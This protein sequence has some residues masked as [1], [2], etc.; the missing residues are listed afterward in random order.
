MESLDLKKIVVTKVFWK[1][2]LNMLTNFAFMTQNGKFAAFINCQKKWND[3]FNKT[4]KDRESMCVCKIWCFYENGVFFTIFLMLISIFPFVNTSKALKYTDQSCCI[5]CASAWQQC[6]IF[7]FA[8][9]TQKQRMNTLS[10]PDHSTKFHKL[11]QCFKPKKK[12][13][14]GYNWIRMNKISNI[15][16]WQTL[17]L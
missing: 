3:D 10:K 4:S 15:W 14:K 11:K 1:W 16:Q 5:A 12:W 9:T 17:I 2:N 13:R 8:K 6:R 7:F